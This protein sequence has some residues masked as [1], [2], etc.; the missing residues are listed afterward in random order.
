[1]MYSFQV[2]VKKQAKELLIGVSLRVLMIAVAT[3]MVLAVQMLCITFWRKKSKQH[4]D[5]YAKHVRALYEN[6]EDQFTIIS[7]GNSRMVVI[8]G[9]TTTTPQS[10]SPKLKRDTTNQS[11]EKI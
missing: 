4:H 7:I 6:R 2:D 10:S 8:C 5:L 3:A 9:S 1:M 11:I